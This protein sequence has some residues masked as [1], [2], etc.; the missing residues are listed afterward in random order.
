MEFPVLE[1][2]RTLLRQV[3][4]T[5]ADDIFQMY[6]DAEA[7]QFR[8]STPLNSRDEAVALIQKYTLDFK[9]GLAVRWGIYHKAD[10]RIIGTI[11]WKMNH[12]ENEFGYSL[13]KFYWRKGYMFEVVHCVINYLFETEE[14]DYITA[15]AKVPNI[16]SQQ[17]LLKAGFSCT[18][19]DDKVVCFKLMY[20]EYLA[21]NKT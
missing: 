9:N 10:Q 21:K 16:A 11:V 17:L 7:M 5:D 13:D 12:P 15:R 4:L 6:S 20:E 2:D 8:E 19:K 3:S 1:T 18:G 14:L